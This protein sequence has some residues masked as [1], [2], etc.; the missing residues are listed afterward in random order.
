[1]IFSIINQSGNL[2]ALFDVMPRLGFAVE[3]MNEAG[4]VFLLSGF[5]FFAFKGS[6]Q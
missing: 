2:H 1:M 6:F 3:G 4:D 5:P